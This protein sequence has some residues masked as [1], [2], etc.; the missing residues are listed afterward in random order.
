MTIDQAAEKAT[1]SVRTIR[2]AIQRGEISHHRMGGAI[3]I[4][5]DDLAAWID[6]K[7]QPATKPSGAFLDRYRAGKA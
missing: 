4:S 5:D 6:S 1:L 3:R 2:R 7:R